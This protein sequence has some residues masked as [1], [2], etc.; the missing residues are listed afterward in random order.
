MLCVSKLLN[1][2]EHAS[3]WTNPVLTRLIAVFVDEI[4]M[5]TSPCEL[6]LTTRGSN[7]PLLIGMQQVEFH[8]LQ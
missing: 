3:V 8:G 2:Q 1:G 7:L 4:D 6:E 5:C